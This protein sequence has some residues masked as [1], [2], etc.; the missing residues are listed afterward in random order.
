M[1]DDYPF[2]EVARQLEKV[3]LLQGHDF[4]QKFTCQGCGARQTMDQKNRLYTTGKCEECGHVT[5]I[6]RA[7]CNYMLIMKVQK[8]KK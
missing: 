6:E 8:G 1:S 4:Y 7:G 5:D 3:H 2:M